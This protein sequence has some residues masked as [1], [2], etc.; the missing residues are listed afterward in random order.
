MST[1]ICMTIIRVTYQKIEKGREE[2][3]KGSW[4]DRTTSVKEDSFPLD[5]ITSAP[6]FIITASTT[7]VTTTA[8]NVMKEFELL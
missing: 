4:N 6:V 2:E 8:G 3:G 1:E 7:S 5:G